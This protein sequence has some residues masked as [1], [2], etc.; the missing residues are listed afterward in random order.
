MEDATR[1]IS[2]I[3]KTTYKFADVRSSLVSHRFYS[4]I[5]WKLRVMF[6]INFENIIQE[7]SNIGSSLPFLLHHA[8][9]IDF[10]LLNPGIQGGAPIHYI[11]M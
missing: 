7:N 3:T 8:V 9:G 1:K 6:P 4:I 10:E 2:T 11:V 5:F